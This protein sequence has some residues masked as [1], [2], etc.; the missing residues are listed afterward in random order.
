MELIRPARPMA[1]RERLA[2]LAFARDSLLCREAQGFTPARQDLFLAT[3]MAMRVIDDHVDRS[4]EENR[5]QDNPVLAEIDRWREAVRMAADGRTTSTDMTAHPSSDPSLEEDI[6]SLLAATL[7][8]AGLGDRPWDALAEA[9]R[10]DARG[11]ELQSFADFLAYAEGATVAPT[12]IFVWLLA[13]DEHA[14]RLSARAANDRLWELARPMATSCYIAHIMRDLVEDAREGAALLTIPFE[15][16]GD[17]A[18]DRNELAMRLTAEEQP[19]V[20][21]LRSR[22]FDHLVSGRAETTA[23]RLELGALLDDEAD[24][25][26]ARILDHYHRCALDLAPGRGVDALGLS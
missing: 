8:H 9:M 10:F 12:Y 22:L 1:A 6:L 21:V 14:G 17:L 4:P 18:N 26:L 5:G 13:C 23:A 20:N 2:R 11:L 24:A 19:L 15:L 7:P 25:R 3:Y 16:Y